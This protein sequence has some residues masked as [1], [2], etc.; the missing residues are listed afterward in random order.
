MSGSC[1]LPGHKLT[2]S[3]ETNRETVEQMWRVI[4]CTCCI[5]WLAESLWLRGTTIKPVVHLPQLGSHPHLP[6]ADQSFASTAHDLPVVRLHR[7]D[8][9]V[10]GVQGRHGGA[11]SEVKHPHPETQHRLICYCEMCCLFFRVITKNV[12]YVFTGQRV[13]LLM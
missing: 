7:G 11:G 6:H 5:L 10:V 8:A 13:L 4:N 9:Q 2:Q 1:F 12:N 3:H